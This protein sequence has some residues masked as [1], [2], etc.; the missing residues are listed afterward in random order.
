MKISS[1]PQRKKY[2]KEWYGRNKENFHAY[3]RMR[4]AEKRKKLAAL[5]SKIGCRVCRENDHRCLQ[6]HH[7]NPL[8]KTNTIS[9]MYAGTWSWTKILQEIEKCEVLCA[10]CHLKLHRDKDDVKRK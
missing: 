9:R 7:I 2:I 8:T 1:T 5:K 10:N 6:F 3:I 4:R